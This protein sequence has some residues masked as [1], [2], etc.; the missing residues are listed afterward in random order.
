[1]LLCV[2]FNLTNQVWNYF[3]FFCKTYFV[4]ENFKKE[5]LKILNLGK[6]GLKLV[7]WKNIS[8]HTHAFYFIIFNA[9]RRVFKNQ[10]IF[11]KMLVF[12]FSIDPICF[13][14]NRNFFKNFVWAS[15]CFDQSKLVNKV[16]KKSVFDLFKTLFQKVFKLSSLPSTRQGSTTYFLSFSS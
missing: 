13:F 8:S 6:L 10:V 3:E 5:C 12:R 7:F 14:I 16:F 11:S 4:F 9:L 15:V 2:S 1:M